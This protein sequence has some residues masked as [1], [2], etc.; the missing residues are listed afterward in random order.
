V[1]FNF[2]PVPRED[3]RVGVPQAGTWVERFS[4]D[5]ARYGGSQLAT[6]ARVDAEM[7]PWQ[8]HPQ[9][10][11]LVLPPLGALVLAPAA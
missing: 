5:D 10:V 9:S 11:R 1:I 7:A 4:S 3:Y 2:T 8:G 6:R